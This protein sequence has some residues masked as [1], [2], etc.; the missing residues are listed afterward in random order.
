MNACA[1]PR[2]IQKLA[3]V[4]CDESDLNKLDKIRGVKW[5]AD[6]LDPSGDPCGR[7]SL[8]SNSA[9]PSHKDFKWSCQ[10]NI[11]FSSDKYHD[12]PLSC[13]SGDTPQEA[14]DAARANFEKSGRLDL[15]DLFRRFNK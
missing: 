1:M 15:S 7:F 10:L 14:Y 12:G 11:H 6:L 2:E 9:L 8:G 3:M 13:G 4:Y 5:Y